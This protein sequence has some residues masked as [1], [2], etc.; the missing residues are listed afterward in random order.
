MWVSDGGRRG[1]AINVSAQPLNK[2]QV[3]RNP[4]YRSFKDRSGPYSRFTIDDKKSEFLITLICLQSKLVRTHASPHETHIQSHNLAAV[5]SGDGSVDG[6]VGSRPIPA[7]WLLQRGPCVF[8][9]VVR[10]P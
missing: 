8:N 1:A 7:G 9:N 3:S 10:W 5:T 6:T 4:H 2:Q